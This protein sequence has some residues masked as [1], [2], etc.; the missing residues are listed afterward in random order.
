MRR[1]YDLGVMCVQCTSALQRAQR[2]T[3]T[4]FGLVVCDDASVCTCDADHTITRLAL[5]TAPL[6][7]I[8]SRYD[9]GDMCAQCMHGTERSQW[10][11]ARAC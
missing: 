5:H 10:Q 11:M 3:A 1:R 8:A 6:S 7:K 9:V 4:Y 2:Q